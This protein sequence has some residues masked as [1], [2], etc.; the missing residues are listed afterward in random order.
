MEGNEHGTFQNTIIRLITKSTPLRYCACALPCK[1]NP[2]LHFSKLDRGGRCLLTPT[3]YSLQC[4]TLH[5]SIRTTM[6]TKTILLLVLHSHLLSLNAVTSFQ[7]SPTPSLSQCISKNVKINSLQWHRQRQSSCND[8]D[9][10]YRQRTLQELNSSNDDNSDEPEGLILGKEISEGLQTLGSEA[11]YL[12]AARKRNEE[13]KA[14]LMEQVRKEEEEAEALRQKKKEEGVQDNY[15]PGD[16][17]GWKG[18]KD[19]GFEAS[20][21][22]DDTGGW[23]EIATAG[24]EGEEEEEPKLFLFG[25]D[26]NA[27]DGSG[28]IL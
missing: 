11:G 5:N 17:S 18:F 6:P 20:E 16:M 19:D 24:G 10:G 28:L 4:C 12:A 27:S 22:N 21:G 2:I 13:A 8:H 3:V 25:D 15:G 7:V 23:G 1:F 14:K 26:D 9:H